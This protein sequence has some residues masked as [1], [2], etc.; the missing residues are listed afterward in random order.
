MTAKWKEFWLLFGV[1][2]FQYCII[3]ISY[4]SLAKGS[5]FWTFSSDIVCGLN[6]YFIIKKIANSEAK[7]TLGIIGYTLGG[8]TGSMMAIWIAKRLVGA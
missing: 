3:C 4:I 7:N 1:Q 6:G 8:A 2:A 5:Y